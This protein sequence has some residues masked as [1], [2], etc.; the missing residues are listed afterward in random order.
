MWNIRIF[1]TVTVR[2]KSFDARAR[3]AYLNIINDK[4][5][6]KKVGFHRIRGF[7][8]NLTRSEKNVPNVPSGV[9]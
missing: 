1:D 7:L 6:T 3:F 9:K 2:D 5:S 8:Y 4:S